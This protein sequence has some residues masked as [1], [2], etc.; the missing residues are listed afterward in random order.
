MAEPGGGRYPGEALMKPDRRPIRQR[1]LDFYT[2]PEIE[3]WLTRPH[4]QLAGRSAAEMVA[5]GEV[6]VVHEIV[7]RL[8]AGGYL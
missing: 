4:P 1:L 2:E 7:D 8:D 6:E 5:A 3:V